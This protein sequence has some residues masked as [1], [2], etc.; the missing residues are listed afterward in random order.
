MSGILA[1]GSLHA[2]NKQ[3]EQSQLNYEAQREATDF[4][5]ES[6]EHV[7]ARDGGWREEDV[8]WREAE[9]SRQLRWR[10][11][12]V[13]WRSRDR[14]LSY[15]WRDEDMTWLA[16]DE[17]AEQLKV[18]AGQAGLLA[19]FAMVAMVETNIPEATSPY[20]IGALALASP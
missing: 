9:L 12:D 10:N 13:A 20:L 15:K 5:K 7:W 4:E 8:A 18:V 11:E 3:L 14:Q 16:V 19:G 1:A 2:T 17:R 6:F